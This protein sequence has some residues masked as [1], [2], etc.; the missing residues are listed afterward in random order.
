MRTATL[1][2][3]RVIHFRRC[4]R[5]AWQRNRHCFPLKRTD[6]TILL[7]FANTHTR[8]PN[9][10]RLITVFCV[11][12]SQ[13][14][15]LSLRRQPTARLSAFLLVSFQK[16]QLTW[17]RCKESQKICERMFVWRVFRSSVE[18]FIALGVLYHTCL[19][20]WPLLSPINMSTMWKEFLSGVAFHHSRAFGVSFFYYAWKIQHANERVTE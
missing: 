10:L 19:C 7:T 3:P 4:E 12:I 15:C 13:L 5:F 14:V 18:T 6:E 16:F 20:V 2:T 11:F 8:T 17:T 1:I 9:S